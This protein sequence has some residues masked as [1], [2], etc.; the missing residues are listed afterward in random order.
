MRYWQCVPSL[1]IFN[2][3][4]TVPVNYRTRSEEMHSCSITSYTRS[5]HEPE[6]LWDSQDPRPSL[7]FV[8]QNRVWALGIVHEDRARTCVLIAE[9]VQTQ[10][11]YS[12]AGQTLLAASIIVL[13]RLYFFIPRLQL[14]S[15]P[16]TELACLSSQ[17][18]YDKE[19]C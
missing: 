10:S 7:P 9:T 17:A 11:R 5:H 1:T 13:L 14:P 6:L 4:R 8:P 2:P 3:S 19:E 18:G 15:F 12:N 16:L